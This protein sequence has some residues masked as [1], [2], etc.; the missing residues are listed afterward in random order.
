[1]E[2][3]TDITFIK[4]FIYLSSSRGITDPELLLH[5]KDLSS[6][7]SAE[8]EVQRFQQNVCSCCAAH[9]KHTMQAS[10]QEALVFKSRVLDVS[11]KHDVYVS[12][13]EDGPYKFSVQLQS[14]SQILRTLMRDINNHPLEPLQE[15]PL[16]G[17]V[18]L[19]R[20]TRDKVLCRAVV[21]SVMEN[22]C[23]LYYVDFGHTEV[24]PYTDIFKLPPHFINP[25]V[26]SI[27]FTLRGVRELDV[28]GTMKEY[29]KQILAGKLLVLHVC[30]PEGPPLIQ[31][32][33][34]Y[35]NGR[36][37]KHIL[38]KAFPPPALLVHINHC[39]YEVPKTLSVEDVVNVYVSFVESYKS[40]FIRLEDYV[41]SLELIMN[42]LADFCTTAPTLSLAE[43]DVGLPCAALY[44]DQWY[45]AEIKD[46][47]GEKIRVVYVD[48]G[49]EETVTVKSL[50]SIRSDLVTTLPAQAIKCT[51]HGYRVIEPTQET[52]DRFQSYTLEKRF[53]IKIVDITSNGL[54]V[55][56]YEKEHN[57]NI[58]SELFHIVPVEHVKNQYSF[59]L[60]L[61]TEENEDISKRHKKNLSI[62]LHQTTNRSTDRAKNMFKN[63]KSILNSNFHHNDSQNE[64]FNRDES[65]NNHST[66]DKWSNGNG[67]KH[68]GNDSSKIGK[69]TR[70]N[71]NRASDT[72]SK[73]STK[74]GK[75]STNNR[76]SYS[77]RGGIS[78]R[79]Q[80]NKCSDKN[81]DG[82]YKNEKTNGDNHDSDRVKKRKGQGYRLVQNKLSIANYTCDEEGQN[83]MKHTNAIPHQI[84]ATRDI[85][86]S[87][88]VVINSLCDFFIQL[89]SDYNALETMMENIASIYENGGG[90]LKKSDM[91][92]GTYCIAQYSK[93]LRWYRAVIK[94]TGE[95]NA[96]V[97]FIDYGNI[98]TVQNDKIKPIQKEFLK[99]PIQAIHCKLFGV[100]DD[101][102][103]SNKIKAFENL[104]INK[105]IETEFISEENGMY[106]V[107][108][109]RMTDNGQAEIFINREF[110]EDAELIKENIT[111]WTTIPYVPGT[112][113]DVV[114][115][116]FTNPNNFYCQIL[117]NEN[118]FKFMMNKI[119]K[120]Y[121][122]KKPI[123]YTLQVII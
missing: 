70:G 67:A 76:G 72:S 24:L 121:I 36:N 89:N 105:T 120:I 90:L 27:R 83:P 39:T 66:K 109:K 123:S 63:L 37:I 88:V 103:N 108:L 11:S 12:F 107:L 95:D 34:L 14:T 99:L 35:D 68:D 111:E 106:S 26:L 47:N 28:T 115:T 85:K 122:T 6:P 79:T 17:S 10:V 18:C 114:I 53:H 91:L 117:D 110:C 84:I 9:Q 73:G 45:R 13:V 113:K 7:D 97:Q 1:M 116:W 112:K 55:D 78:I 43:L 92:H 77:R 104:V 60:V 82:N 62:S 25:R 22:K 19:G 69:G 31:Y 51:L 20:Y 94:F 42:D 61:K 30:P 49:N 3:F 54:V 74:H 59:K 44:D 96:T 65:S 33:D 29:F 15:P 80:S 64:R 16:P 102:L 71:R 101:N 87:E 93:D 5:E 86:S 81:N 2:E 98:E 75:S 23:K 118:E 32:G 48:Y 46:I 57:M 52:H 4:A 50:R 21:M 38:K 58:L 41:P 40:F 119:Q 8:N 56:L 100:K